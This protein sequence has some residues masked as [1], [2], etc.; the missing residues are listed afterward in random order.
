M[1]NNKGDTMEENYFNQ[2]ISCSV[3]HCKYYDEKEH[4]CSLGSI[5]VGVNDSDKTCC[6]TYE[7]SE[8]E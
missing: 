4:R 2:R 5:E 6:E 1:Q 8:L 3:S 7:K